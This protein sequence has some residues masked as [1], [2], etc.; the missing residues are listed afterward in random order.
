VRVELIFFSSREC[1]RCLALK[2][3][4]GKL[5]QR[6]KVSFKEVD[7]GRNPEIA[8]Q[9]MVFSVPV[10]VVEVDGKETARWAGIFSLYV[11]ETFLK[12]LTALGS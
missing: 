12:R 2:A 10:V 6:C 3:K 4:L 5:A 8:A 11:V 7:I 9:R 1:K